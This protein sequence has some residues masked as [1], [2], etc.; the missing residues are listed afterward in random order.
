MTSDGRVWVATGPDDDGVPHLLAYSAG[1]RLQRDLPVSGYEEG[2]TLGLTGVAAWRDGGVLALDA[3]NARVLSFDAGGDGQRTLTEIPDI[4]P[5]RLVVAAE[6]GC[7]AGLTDDAPLLRGV[8]VARTGTIYVTDA[9]QGTIWRIDGDG[10]RPE[11]FATDTAWSADDGLGGIA[12]AGDGSLL[13][14]SPQ[15][16]DPATAGGGA[17]YRIGVSAQGPQPK[18]LITEF[19]P[20]EAPSGV[21]SADDGSIVVTLRDADEI[22]LLDAQGAETQRIGGSADGR[23]IDAPAGA[24]FHGPVLLVANRA[25]ESPEDRAVLSV[26]IG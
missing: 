21:A 24:A 12:V 9:A 2:S 8:A 14:T 18:E 25:P 17:L 15:A 5:C 23:S 11:A 22:V 3:S 26:G 16:L 19:G 4:P 13:V 20:G 7:E 1:G 6:N 10:G